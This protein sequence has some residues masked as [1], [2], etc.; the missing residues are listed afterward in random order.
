[1]V[2]CQIEIYFCIFCVFGQFSRLLN[3]NVDADSGL[4]VELA[5]LGDLHGDLTTA[6][7]ATQV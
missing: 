3:T 4:A 5:S 7:Q 2:T 1:M 6:D